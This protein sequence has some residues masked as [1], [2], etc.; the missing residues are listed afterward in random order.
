MM[1]MMMMIDAI[2][3]RL[4]GNGNGKDRDLMDPWDSQ[5]NVNTSNRGKGMV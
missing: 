1:M 4:N 2:G 5:G 3:V